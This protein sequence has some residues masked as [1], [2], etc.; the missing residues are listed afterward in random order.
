MPYLKVS[1]S[2]FTKIPFSTIAQILK[3]IEEDTTGNPVCE[4]S[5]LNILPTPSISG[6][7]ARFA[8]GQTTIKED[9]RWQTDMS[10]AKRL[11]S[12]VYG[13]ST[14]SMFFL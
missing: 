7:P 13:L 10:I 9:D 2:E 4:G 12:D 6:N 11:M 5:R 3:F 8:E 14:K 1:Y